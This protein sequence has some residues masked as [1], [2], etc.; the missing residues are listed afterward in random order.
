MSYLMPRIAGRL[1]GEPLMVD[2]SKLAAFMAGLGGRIVEGGLVLPGVEAVDHTAFANGRPSERAGIVGDPMGR[3]LSGAES[4]GARILQRDGAVAIIP[5]EGTLV[6]KGKWLGQNS[7]ET[8]YEGVRALANLALADDNVK[9]VVLE[10]D[11]YGGEVAGALADA[12]ADGLPVGRVA[13]AIKGHR[14]A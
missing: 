14:R 6:Q 13:R 9:G 7:G 2:Q 5:I 4:R 3:A 8:S 11:S 12:I 1:F 10:V